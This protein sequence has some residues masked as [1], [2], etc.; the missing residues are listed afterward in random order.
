ME[1]VTLAERY[2]AREQLAGNALA[3][4]W[5]AED[6]VL[7]RP[8]ALQVLARRLQEDAAAVAIFEHETERAMA[9]AGHAH[10][11]TILRVG[12][13]DKGPAIVAELL[14]GSTVRTALADDSRPA[15]DVALRWV[16]EAASAL[17]AA[18]EQGLLHR[19]VRPGNLMLDEHDGVV[20]GDF[21]IARVAYESA[22]V[23]LKSVVGTAAYLAPEQILDEPPAAASDRYGLA[24]LAYELLTGALPHDPRGSFEAV[25]RA[26]LEEDPVPASARDASLPAALDDV[27]R[28]GLDRDPAARWPSAGAFAAEL[29]RALGERPGAAVP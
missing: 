18:H 10:A 29:G 13:H 22:H 4:V 24:V 26:T 14:P 3:S 23:A 16:T 17:D 2:L 7:D 8:V 19:D 25:A 5:I 6:L 27:L 9:L 28:R 15:P 1:I 11:L 20:V 12:R 21:G